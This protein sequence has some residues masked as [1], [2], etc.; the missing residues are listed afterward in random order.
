MTEHLCK[1]N[2]LIIA[3]AILAILTVGCWPMQAFAWD[4]SEP[5]MQAHDRSGIAPLPAQQDAPIHV[6]KKSILFHEGNLRR[7][8]AIDIDNKSGEDRTLGIELPLN[9]FLI[10][11]IIPKS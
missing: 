8:E 3:V 11:K 6:D 10:S 2:A 9:G 5:V 1:S 4:V 7:G